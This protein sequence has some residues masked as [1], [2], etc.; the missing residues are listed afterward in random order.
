MRTENFEKKFPLWMVWRAMPW[1]LIAL[2]AFALAALAAL[3]YLGGQTRF[4]ADDFCSAYYAQRFGLLRSIW[5][6]YR[7]WSVGY[8]AFA[9][10]WLLLETFGRHGA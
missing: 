10:D 2:I 8:T 5:Y 6:W 4:M 9:F 7:T 1:H 3:A